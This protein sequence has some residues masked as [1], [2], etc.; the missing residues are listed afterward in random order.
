MAQRPKPAIT[1]EP[2]L[3]SIATDDS[4]SN[5]THEQRRKYSHDIVRLIGPK[6]PFDFWGKDTY[7]G[8]I[9]VV[10][11]ASIVNETYLKQTL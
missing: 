6:R 8:R 4:N 1:N 7:L 10:G 5:R 11:N 2:Y 3:F 9:N